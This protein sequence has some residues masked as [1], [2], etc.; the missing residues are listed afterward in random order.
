M[1][2]VNPV[3][4]KS[5]SVTSADNPASTTIGGVA[6]RQPSCCIGNLAIGPMKVGTAF[7]DVWTAPAQPHLDSMVDNT[8]N[9]VLGWTNAASVSVF[10]QSAPDAAGTYTDI[11]STATA[12]STS[13]SYTVSP[14]GQQYFRLRY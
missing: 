3:D 7:S 1:L 12:P 2:W 13:G 9:L 6:L 11:D 14:T 8:G 10:L 4:A 5:P